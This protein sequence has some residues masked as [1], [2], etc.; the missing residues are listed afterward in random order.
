[1]KRRWII[2]ADGTWDEP[3]QTDQG[4]PSPTNVVKNAAVKPLDKNNTPQS[5]Y[6]HL[7]VGKSQGIGSYILGG[8]FGAGLSKN[9]MDMYTFLVLNYSEGDESFL[10]GF[11]R[12]AYAVRSLAGF[13]RNCGILKVDNITKILEAYKLYRDRSDNSHPSAPR[14]IEFRHDYSW[15]D[16]NIKFIDVW[17]TVGAL[18]I[19][20]YGL[21][22][23]QFEFHD[24]QLSSMS[25]SRIKHSQ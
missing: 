16:F 4:V 22:L 15:P 5:V 24:V 7:G 19:P 18:G 14:S 3:G 12:G 25:I 11:S 23:K 10:F 21:N 6:Y 13:I 20:F 1:M 9:I 8:A 17:D 2:C